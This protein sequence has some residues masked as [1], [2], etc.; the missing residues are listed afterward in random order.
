MNELKF[1]KISKNYNGEGNLQREP[2]HTLKVF[3]GADCNASLEVI[4]KFITK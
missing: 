1:F 2:E 4:F 3:S